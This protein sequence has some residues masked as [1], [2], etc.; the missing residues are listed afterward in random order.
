MVNPEVNLVQVDSHHLICSLVVLHQEDNV[1]EAQDK[2][3]LQVVCVQ[4]VHHHKECV[5]EGL[6]Q[7]A[8][9]LQVAEQATCLEILCR[10]E[11][12]DSHY[13]ILRINLHF[14]IIANIV[15]RS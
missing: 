8:R 14:R 11:H 12:A 6:H 5:Q 10:S 7:V 4:E 1:Q 9:D 13:I 3:H 15:V 2:D